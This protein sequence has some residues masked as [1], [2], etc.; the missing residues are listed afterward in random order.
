VSSMSEIWS[1]DEFRA[2]RIYTS[3]LPLGRGRSSSAR[4]SDPERTRL[5][6]RTDESSLMCGTSNTCGHFTLE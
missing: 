1:S 6:M 4:Y 5:D 2:A 3:S